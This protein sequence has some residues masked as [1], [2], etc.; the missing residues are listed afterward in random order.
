MEK[1]QEFKAGGMVS[2]W[3]GNFSSD[4]EFD[5]YMN[6]SKEFER[7]FGFEIHDRSIR[8]AVVE[9]DPRPI[10]QLV[11]GFSDWKSFVSAV[12]EAAEE[13]GID[14]AT[15]MI[16]FYGVKFDPVK[17]VIDANAPLK[18]LGAFPFS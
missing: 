17:V 15:T 12:A 13:S 7:D 5:R 16:V 1:Q 14:L 18:F 4:E 11:E 6:L 10:A 3:V 8:E 9:K 2:I